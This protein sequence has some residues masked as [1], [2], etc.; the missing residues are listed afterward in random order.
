M[1]S[2]FLFIIALAAIVISIA[3]SQELIKPSKKQ[4][5]RKIVTLTAG[6]S[7]VTLVLTISL[8]QGILF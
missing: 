7:L 6:G 4:N 2:T 3:L 8:F 1:S 5:G